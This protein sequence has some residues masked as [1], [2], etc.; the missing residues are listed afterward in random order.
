[1]SN[2]LPLMVREIL[3]QTDWT[4]NEIA[5]YSALLEKGAMGLTDL[6]S[7]TS[8][9]ISTLQHSIKKLMLKKMIQKSLING[10]PVYSAADIDQLK[11]WSKGYLKKYQQF[12]NIIENF[13]DQYDFNPQMYTPKV[14]LYEGEKGVKQ[15]YRTILNECESGEMRSM[16]SLEEG[17][18][19]ALEEFFIKE[20]NVARAEK[21]KKLRC[22]AVDCPEA[23]NYLGTDN[24]NLRETKVIPRDFFLPS[25]DADITLFDES[26]H[27]MSANNKS[28]VSML[29]KDSGLTH[30]LRT[31][32]DLFW[33]SADK[34]RFYEGI[35]GIKASYGDMIKLCKSKQIYGFFAVIEDVQPELQEFFVKKYVKH[36]VKERIAI[37]NIALKSPKAIKYKERDG[38]ELRETVFVTEDFFPKLNSEVNLFDGYIHCM[39]F[40]KDGGFAFI[41]KDKYMAQILMGLFKIA[42]KSLK[43]DNE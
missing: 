30:I 39:S 35:E 15:S 17:K 7:E 40:D 41:V 6:A 28:I 12:E 16:F 42:W 2:Y 18:S 5:A 14:R 36:R 24:E 27:Y 19:S 37:K 4:E 34:L 43:K 32:F 13:V 23:R 38:K 10:K 26:L 29:I 8:I 21:G 25:I 22:L 1:M 3:I 33:F 20:Y 9:S 31:I 11:K